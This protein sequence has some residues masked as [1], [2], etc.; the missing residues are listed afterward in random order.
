VLDVPMIERIRGR[1]LETALDVGCGEGRFG[2]IM[3][4]HG[5]RPVGV[6]PTETPIRRAT[7]LDPGGDPRKAAHYRRVPYFYIMEWQKPT[8]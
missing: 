6:D 4:A 5:I 3:R 8:A 1:R 7:Q 2:R